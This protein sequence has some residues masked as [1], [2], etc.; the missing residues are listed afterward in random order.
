VAAQL[1]DQLGYS[2]T[3]ASDGT[4]AVELYRRARSEGSPFDLVILDVTVAGGMGGQ[5]AMERL[6]TLDPGVCAIV[7]SGY[8][9]GPVLAHH[10]DYGFA[11]VL[12]KPFQAGELARIVASALHRADATSS[13]A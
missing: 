5:E 6:L 12:A 1:L 13:M 8:V 2:V 4:E 3:L 10:R 9:N 11:G 7:T